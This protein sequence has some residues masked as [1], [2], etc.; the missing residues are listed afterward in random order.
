MSKFA[1]C[2]LHFTNQHIMQYSA[3]FFIFCWTYLTSHLLCKHTIE[4]AFLKCFVYTYRVSYILFTFYVGLIL[5]ALVC[6]HATCTSCFCSSR[7]ECIAKTHIV[8]GS[9]L[10]CDC[11]N[12]SFGHAE[13]VSCLSSVNALVL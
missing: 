3:G 7:F 12:L 13:L 5:F 4:T 10:G 9:A 6:K 2:F 11:S 8:A 1:T